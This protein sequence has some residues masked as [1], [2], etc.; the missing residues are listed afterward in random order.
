M[1]LGVRAVSRSSRAT[2]RRHGSCGPPRRPPCRRSWGLPCAASWRPGGSSVAAGAL[3]RHVMHVAELWRYPV[4]SLAGERL[5]RAEIRLDGVVGDRLVQVYDARGRMITARTRSRLL[6]HRGTLGPDGEPRVDSWPWASPEAAALIADAVGA[7]AR[8][9]R[10]TGEERFDVLP[11]LIATDG[12]IAA[13]AVDG[14][15]LRPNVVVG[16][17]DGLAER[18]WPGRRLRIGEVLV[19]VA[20]LRDRCVMTTY[21]PDTQVQDP[22]VLRRIVREFGGSMALDCA[23][24]RAGRVRVG[25]PVALL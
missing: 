22:S 13:L 8:L 14:R 25:D 6:G 23:V 18:E 2:C 17:V 21:D 11:L 9:D 15:R 4:K 5:E 24:E 7:E 19:A 16:G 1:W 3:R 20:Q 12:A 10:F